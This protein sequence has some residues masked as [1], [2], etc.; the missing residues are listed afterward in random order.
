MVRHYYLCINIGSQLDR[1]G[2]F[3]MKYTNLNIKNTNNTFKYVIGYLS[4]R[5]ESVL[6]KTDEFVYSNPDS[7][8][9]LFKDNDR[10]VYVRTIN[11][12]K[13]SDL[14]DLTWSDTNIPETVNCS[15]VRVYFPEFSVDTYE[16]NVHYMLDVSIWIHGT[17]IS[18]GSFLLNRNDAVACPKVTRILDENYYECIDIEIPDPM[19]IIYSDDWMTFRETECGKK[20]SKTVWKNTSI[21]SDT[22]L[23]SNSF[24]NNDDIPCLF[25]NLN[26][27][28]KT[29]NEYMK[30]DGYVGCQGSILMAELDDYLSLNLSQ[31]INTEDEN[32][33]LICRPVM[34]H[35]YRTA[36]NKYNIY[37]YFRETYDL[38][39]TSLVL[40]A[41]VSDEDNIYKCISRTISEDDA[42]NDESWIFNIQGSEEFTFKD[43]SEWDWGMSIVSTLTVKYGTGQSMFV[44]SNSIP[45][46]PDLFRFMI[47]NPSY[48]GSLKNLYYINLDD[49]DMTSNIVNVVNKNVQNIIQLENN[50]DGKSKFIKSVFFRTHDLANIIV[51]P[52]V[53]ENICINLDSYKSKVS[54]FSIQIENTIFT[55]TGRN[56]SG[57]LF[58]IVGSKLPE[59]LTSGTYYILDDNNE[60]ITS[61]KYVYEY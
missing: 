33:S 59:S 12:W 56:N 51:H 20:V 18:L 52:D 45:I 21:W 19:D 60:M 17:T 42:M 47:Y 61:G 30:M 3:K 37:E 28:V 32:S 8:T 39:P 43:W 38:D 22:R 4:S 11:E 27:V 48:T 57:V 31:T 9:C 49:I 23:W 41:V 46:T 26:A 14:V 10:D 44:K 40:E 36:D 25:I 24:E 58:K 1:Y 55:E 35:T 34:N 16:H 2:K 29:D 50:V 53:T 5:D 54:T 15:T 6:G 13:N 7:G